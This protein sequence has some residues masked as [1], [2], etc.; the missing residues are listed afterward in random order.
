MRILVGVKRVVDYAVK[1]RVA[2]DGR[3]VELANTKMSMNPFCEIAVE[4]AVRIKERTKSAEV[5]ALSIGPKAC[6]ETLRTALAIGADRAVHVQTDLR[7]DQALQPL[8]VAKLF[9]QVAE[10]ERVDLVLLGKQSIDGDN[11]QTG[12]MLAGLLGWPQV[13]FAAKVEMHDRDLVVERETDSG[14]EVCRLSLP[15]VVTADLRLNEP[16]YATL[17]SIMKA[18][19]KPL[20]VLEASSL[21]SDLSPRNEVQ[22][23]SEPPQRPPGKVVQT[24]DELLASLRKEAVIP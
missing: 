22:A 23:V 3:G 4:E 9:R 2:A 14:T 5:V 10:R 12:A 13:T 8:A 6:Q 11:C 16:R 19:K 17:P 1:V 21:E 18:K 24:V 15:C 7:T 20:E